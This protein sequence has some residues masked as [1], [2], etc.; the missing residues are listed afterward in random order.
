[1]QGPGLV[2]LS[3]PL[4]TLGVKGRWE[5]EQCLRT[6][7]IRI[8]WRENGKVMGTVCAGTSGGLRCKE[9]VMA[10]GALKAEGAASS[11][12]PRV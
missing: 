12:D 4:V 1:M 7:R 9:Q 10:L 11:S 3:R 6:V 2:A 8:N 5:M